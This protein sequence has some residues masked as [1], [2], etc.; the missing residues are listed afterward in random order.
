MSVMTSI[1]QLEFNYLDKTMTPTVKNFLILNGL[2]IILSAGVFYTGMYLI[3][4]TVLDCSK[5]SQTTSIG[6]CLATNQI[7]SKRLLVA[8]LPLVGIT[9]FLLG[10]PILIVLTLAGIK[11]DV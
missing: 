5:D 11:K 8:E 2:S 4:N 3:T 1:L 10:N 7:D 9:L 6:T